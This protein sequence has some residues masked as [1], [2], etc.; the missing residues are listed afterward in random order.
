[1]GD[2]YSG[3]YQQ[4]ADKTEVLS[5]ARDLREKLLLL[6]SEAPRSDGRSC[7]ALDRAV[8]ISGDFNGY[9]L[10]SIPRSRTGTAS[11]CGR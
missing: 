4:R 9:A 1:M 6:A 7:R 10:G 2:A 5:A 8:G 3:V 11:R